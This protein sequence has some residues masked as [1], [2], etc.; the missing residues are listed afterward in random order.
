MEINAINVIAQFAQMYK[1]FNFFSN[2]SQFKFE[3]DENVC[4]Y[5]CACFTVNY[6]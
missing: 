4:V 5:V 3:I 1:F 2:I 6:K